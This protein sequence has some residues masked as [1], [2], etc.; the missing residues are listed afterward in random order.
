MNAMRIFR[1]NSPLMRF[2][3][4]LAD[5]MIL[6]V[7]YVVCCLPIITAGAA[8]T[9]LYSCTMKLDEPDEQRIIRRFFRAF[10]ADYG[11]SSALFFIWAVAMVLVL[12]NLWFYFVLLRDVDGWYR[13]LPMIPTVL[14]LLFSSYL[15]PL[16]AYFDNGFWQLLKNALSLALVHLPMTAVITAI[17][18]I[19][20][21]L[22]Y[23]KTDVF[24]YLMAVWTLF[25]FALI[26]YMNGYLCKTVFHKHLPQSETEENENEESI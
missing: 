4:R 25:G 3:N 17:N 22:L 8:T 9:A 18:C 10:C 23:F 2:L 19:P 26:A 14:L 20:V 6:N 15:F 13:I 16:Q 7:L 11:R 1:Y 12:I 21:L 5:I 24:V